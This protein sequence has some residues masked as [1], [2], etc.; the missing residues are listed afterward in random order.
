MPGWRTVGADLDKSDE[1]LE[2]ITAEK[3]AELDSELIRT[4]EKSMRSHYKTFT[5]VYPQLATVMDPIT[6]S[7]IQQRL[8]NIVKD[9]CSDWRIMKTVGVDLTDKY[10]ALDFICKQHPSKAN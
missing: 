3:V 9:M 4:Y 1:I 10:G 2:T 7:N 5:D 8:D 6:K